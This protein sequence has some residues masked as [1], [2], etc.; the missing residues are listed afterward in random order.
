M[1]I[2]TLVTASLLA[3]VAVTAALSTAVR[4]ADHAEADTASADDVSADI[5]DLFAFHADGRL[6]LILTYDG[7][8]LLSDTA[9][10]DAD[11]IYGFHIDTDGDNESDHDIWARFG[12]N[13]AGEWGLQVQGLPGTEGALVGPVEELINDTSSDAQAFAGMRD[14]PFFFDRE[15]FLDTLMTGTLSFDPNRDFVA[16]KNTMAIAVEFEH[17]NLGTNDIAIWAT[18]G[19]L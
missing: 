18:T 12:Q 10:Y 15:G 17:A 3:L 16:V 8:L 19:R 5:G 9:T 13:T 6:T 2:K 11:V 4:A 14:D 7:Y 1:K